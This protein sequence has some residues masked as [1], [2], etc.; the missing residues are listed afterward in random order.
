MLIPVLERWLR[1][2]ALFTPTEELGGLKLPGTSSR[3]SDPLP[4]SK[5]TAHT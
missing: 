5:G 2:R 3:G 4:D 1:L